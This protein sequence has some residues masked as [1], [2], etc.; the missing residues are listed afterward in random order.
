MSK[1]CSTPDGKST[2]PEVEMR[3][4]GSMGRLLSLTVGGSGRLVSFRSLEKWRCMSVS[5]GFLAS[6]SSFIVDNR[7]L[8]LLP[9]HTLYLCSLSYVWS[10]LLFG[11]EGEA[12]FVSYLGIVKLTDSFFRQF[13][14]YKT[15]ERTAEVPW[16]LLISS[17]LSLWG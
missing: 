3:T 12:R 13:L 4:H 10:I 16:A 11:T 17:S 1:A 15:I 5:L 6:L 7:R 9:V 14:P 8:Q 2:V